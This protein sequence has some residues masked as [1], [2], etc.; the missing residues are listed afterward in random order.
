LLRHDRDSYVTIN[1]QN[2]QAGTE[3]NFDKYD[4]SYA[5]PYDVAYDY[6]S[7][8]HYDAYAFSANGLPT[9][10]PHVSSE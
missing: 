3:Y 6:S 7:V 5:H 2:I 8:M 1:W 9:I 10:T 4:Q